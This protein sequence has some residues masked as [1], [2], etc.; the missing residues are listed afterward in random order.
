M[1]AIRYFLFSI[2]S[3]VIALPLAFPD[4]YSNELVALGDETDPYEP[5]SAS[6]DVSQ[7]TNDVVASLDFCKARKYQTF[8]TPTDLY[9]QSPLQI[10][11]KKNFPSLFSAFRKHNAR[12]NR[13]PSSRR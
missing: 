13:T 4:D 8:Q 2:I 9:I 6:V 1:V 12:A 10:P 11:F 5:N 7:S 3:T